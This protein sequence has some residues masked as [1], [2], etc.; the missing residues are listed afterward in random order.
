MLR[1]T[2][3]VVATAFG[4]AGTL[5]LAACSSGGSSGTAGSSS[6][7]AT[8]ASASATASS[9]AA[10]SGAPLVI[11]A[12]DQRVAVLKPFAA[13]FE[14][15]YGVTVDLRA[16]N[17]SNLQS[18]F[19]TAAQHGTGPDIVVLANDAIGNLVQNGAIEPVQLSSAAQAAFEPTAI[20]AMKYNGQIYGVPYDVENIGLIRNTKLAPTAPATIDQLISEGNKLKAEGK[21]SDSLCLQSGTTGD[22]YHIFPFYTS[23]GGQLFGTTSNGNLDPNQVLIDSKSSVT[24]WSKLGA[25][26]MKGSGALST[27]I[28][29]NNAIPAFTSGKCAF[30]VSGPWAIAA[31]KTAKVPY[32]I[33]PIPPFAGGQTARP[34]LGV[35]AFFVSGKGKDPTLAQ[36]FV[37]TYVTQPAVQIAL[38]KVGDRPEALTAA[39]NSSAQTDPDIAK[40]EAAGAGGVPMPDIPAMNQVW[41][42]M[43]ALEAAVIAGA[44]P[45]TAAA[46]AQKSI[47]KAIASS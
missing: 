10:A 6:S 5:A 30:L 13:Q 21:V 8:S 37:T 46:A 33:S 26:G 45:S 27:A 14:K 44:N 47:Q 35:S 11:W 9:P 12:D 16:F 24:A 20:N 1:R 42:P 19:V 41:T 32:A 39:L 34:F 7:P 22:A 18:D 31:I 4:L 28:N 43:G 29:S 17:F 23:A 36:T 3:G 38:Y 2:A 25:I 40:W 15:Q